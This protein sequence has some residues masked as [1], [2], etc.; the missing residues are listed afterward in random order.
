MLKIEIS[1]EEKWDEV[2]E[3]FTTPIKQVV[4]LEH[5]LLSMSK[6]EAKWHKPYLTTKEKTFEENLHYIVCMVTN[7]NFDPNL[8]YL[9]S[10]DN[11][12][13]ISAYINDPMTATI[14]HKPNKKGGKKEVVTSELIYYYMTVFNIPVEFERWHLNRLMT[15]IQV[16]DVKQDGGGTKMSKEEVAS[17]NAA[18]NEANKAKYGSNG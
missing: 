5:S 13:A 7:Q 4:Q 18:I 6:W 16:C 1:S 12:D 14:I 15:L 10:D 3:C 2:N 9:L 11:L 8:L 17:R